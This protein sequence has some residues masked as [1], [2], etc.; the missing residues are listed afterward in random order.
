MAAPGR[1]AES[2][3]AEASV[4]A[5]IKP[6]IRPRM[7]ELEHSGPVRILMA[8]G[9][10]L[11]PKAERPKVRMPDADDVVPYGVDVHLGWAKRIR[12]KGL[13]RGTSAA[14]QP[15]AAPGPAPR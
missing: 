7:E 5:P 14:A 4:R 3:G 10:W 11:V 6:E 2:L 12:L 13:A 1:G 15:S 9:R 8:R